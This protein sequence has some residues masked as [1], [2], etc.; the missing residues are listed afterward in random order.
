MYACAAMPPLMLV[1]GI[2]ILIVLGLPIVAVAVASKA[3]RLARER[4]A[5]AAKHFE[6]LEAEVRS[7]RHRLETLERGAPGPAQ[8]LPTAPVA[9]ARVEPAPAVPTPPAAGPRAE[10]RPAVST[11]SAARPPIA[12]APAPVPPAPVT[13]APPAEPPFRSTS[14]LLAA[15]GR[16]GTTTAGL[17]ERI[18]TR[19]ATWVGIVAIVFGV[20]FFLRWTFENNIIGPAGR[21]ILG[22]VS[23]VAFLAAGLALHRRRD[24]PFLSDGLSGGGLALLYL[25]LYAAYAFYHFV[26]SGLALALMSIVTVAGAL[27]SVIGRH[28]ATAVLAVLG[29]LITPILLSSERPQETVLLSY[30]LVLDLFVLAVARFR[31]WPALNRLAWCGTVILLVPLLVRFPQAPR[32]IVRLVLLSA[33]FVLFLAVP[34]IRSWAERRPAAA[35]DLVLIVG[36]AAAYFA[37][38]YATLEKWQPRG[39]APY[40]WVLAAVFAVVAARHRERVPE[41]AA[42]E[43]VLS[44]NALVLLLISFPIALDGPWI[45]LAWAATGAV[46]S[47][48]ARRYPVPGALGW[49]SLS[50]ALAASRVVVFDPLWYPGRPPVWNVAFL[51]HVLVVVAL[52]FCGAVLAMKG[53]SEDARS[54]AELRT[55]LWF[56]AA[57]LLAVLL[58]REPP[59]LW[60]AALLTLELLAL[61]WLANVLRD[62]SFVIAT[63]GLA[64]VLLVRMLVADHGIARQAAQDLVNGPVLLRIAACVALGIAGSWLARSEAGERAIPVGRAVSALFGFALLFVLSEGWVDHERFL[65]EQAMIVEPEALSHRIAWRLQVGLSVLWTFYAAATLAWGFLTRTPVVRHAA[66]ALLGLV[67]VKVFVVDLSELQAI[68]RILSF[69]V[70]GLVLLG[71]SFLY[72]KRMRA[73]AK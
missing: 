14:E 57:S 27:V 49:G 26:G 67:I 15:P 54:N 9:G 43:F 25:S 62:P 47:A 58:W 30:L 48:L 28:Q 16:P 51:I 4:E 68:Y 73:A 2:L 45:T 18:G 53:R 40:A 13:Q 70:L 20:G 1:F 39:E 50:L 5:G 38:V 52:A 66:L 72:Q 22:L 71:V 21:V 60:P 34:F 10:P 3:L 65:L 12:P 46:L 44:G 64:V 32:P 7:L 55:V 59:G 42:G 17:E 31:S 11:P 6:S 23:G 35:P 19:W 36:N 69:L 61:A 29:G 24:L 33:I 56:A 37:A 63:P 8:A 41:D